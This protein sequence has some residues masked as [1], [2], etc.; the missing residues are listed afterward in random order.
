[1]ACL[2]S[3]ANLDRGQ[4]GLGDLQRMRAVIAA[5]PDRHIRGGFDFL[6]QSAVEQRLDR[7]GGAAAHVGR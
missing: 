7:L 5:T 1:L 2:V 4:P 3:V 6:E